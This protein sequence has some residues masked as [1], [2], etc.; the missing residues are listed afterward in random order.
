MSD[1]NIPTP[2]GPSDE[3]IATALA[4]LKTELESSAFAAA[5]VKHSSLWI[6]AAVVFLAV[7]AAGMVVLGACGMAGP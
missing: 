6:T 3:D 2:A 5:A 7:W 1:S 4:R